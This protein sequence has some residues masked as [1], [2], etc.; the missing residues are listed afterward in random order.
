MEGCCVID[1]P[2]TSVVW[3][4]TGQDGHT[5]KGCVC[6]VRYVRSHRLARHHRTLS[7][8]SAMSGLSA[9]R[10][11]SLSFLSSLPISID[12]RSSALSPC[13]ALARYRD[14]QSVSLLADGTICIVS[15]RLFAIAEFIVRHWEWHGKMPGETPEVQSLQF[16]RSGPR[17]L[18]SR[19]WGREIGPPAYFVEPNP[20]ARAALQTYVNVVDA[21]D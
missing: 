2:R 8:V 11:S 10:L 12:I 1:Q 5:L 14:Q 18:G 4:D 21:H 16:W 15:L 20:Y 6:P 13:S 7:A 17:N 3:T 19:G 9:S